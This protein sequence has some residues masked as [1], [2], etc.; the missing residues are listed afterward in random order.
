V[1]AG[2]NDLWVV[3]YVNDIGWTTYGFQKSLWLTGVTGASVT[4]YLRPAL[5]SAFFEGGVGVA[6]AEWL[7]GTPES[8]IRGS[9]LGLWGGLGYEVG[10]RLVA[11]ITAT[12]YGLAHRGE[13][14]GMALSL[15]YARF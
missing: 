7:T 6:L 8:A 4:R 11:R 2:I 12:H 1:G 9:G 14:L 10:P 5:R 15:D 13:L 3:S